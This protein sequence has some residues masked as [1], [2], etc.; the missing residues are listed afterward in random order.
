MKKFSWKKAL[1]VATAYLTVIALAIGGT[2]A[3]L[4]DEDSDVN[5]MTLGNVDIDQIFGG[6]QYGVKGL[7]EYT[8]VT[9]VYNNDKQ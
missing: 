4:Q 2:L 5:V 8:G 9:V 6:D 1:L 3:Y 7:K